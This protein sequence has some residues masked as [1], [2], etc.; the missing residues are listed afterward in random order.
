LLEAPL[1]RSNEYPRESLE[2]FTALLDG[3]LKKNGLY[4]GQVT[5]GRITQI[6]NDF[7]LVDIGLKTEGRVPLSEFGTP[8]NRGNVNVGD[9]VDVYVERIENILGE[10]VLSCDRARR[11]GAW[12]ELENA[13]VEKRNVEGAISARVKGG[14]TVD[15]GGAQAFLPGSQIDIRPVADDQAIA[16][17]VQDFQILKIDKKRNNIVVSR[18]AVLEENRV[19][20]RNK[21]IG[22][23]EEG[24]IVE[25]IVKNITDY[26]A[27]VDLGGVDGLLHVTQ[28]SWRRISDPN[29]VLKAG[30][31]IQVKIIRINNETQRVNLSMKH[32]AQDPWESISTKYSAGSKVKG[33]ITNTTEYGAFVELEPGIEGLVHVS[34]MSWT[35]KNTTPDKITEIN[36]EV[37][38]IVLEVDFTKRRISLGM[39]QCQN[40]PWEQY[41]EDCPVGSKIKG[42]IKNITDFGLFIG[43]TDELDGMV[44]ISDLSWDIKGEEAIKQYKIDTEVEVLVL[45]VEVD[46][47]R[48][49]LGIKQISAGDIS[50]LNH[51]KNGEVVTCT[52][53]EAKD[54]GLDVEIASSGVRGFIRRADLAKDRNDQR[55]ERFAKDQ[56]VDVKITQLDLKT[57]KITLSIRAL[58]SDEEKEALKQYGSTDSGASLGDILGKAFAGFGRG[59]KKGGEETPE[60]EEQE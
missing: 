42:T 52:V 1:D 10:A 13:F 18:R 23:L 29:E 22:N 34:E 11:E 43:L 25:G 33:R 44:H 31:A 28:I 48:I 3:S 50:A 6:E 16:D 2:E 7:A 21:M 54:S 55:P 46:K 8:G 35:K 47:E 41:L 4:E 12:L 19:H 17:H 30:E 32:L 58:E 56:K 45:G 38:A 39:K 20:E 9:E 27:F 15:L 40:N 5:K 53:L 24:Q 26:G 49:S 36:Q 59:K 14:F 37:E 60:K 51:L 57:N